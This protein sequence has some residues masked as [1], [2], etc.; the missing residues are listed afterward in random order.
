MCPLAARIQRIVIAALA[1][2]AFASALSQA[3]AQSS[4]AAG[5]APGRDWVVDPTVPGENLPPVGRSLFDFVVV[6]SQGARKAYDVPFPITALMKK[7][8]AELQPQNTR[9]PPLKAVLIPLGRSL[10][11]T[12]P[13]PDFFAY[14]RLVFTADAE[15]RTLTGSAGML[16]KDRI[17][18]GYQEKADLIEVI[19]YNEAAGRF[20]FQVVKDYRAGSTP[21]VFYANRAICTSCHQ[22]AAPI[23]SRQLWDETNAN[24][25]IAALLQKEKRSF[26]GVEPDRGVDIPYGL[27][28]ATDRANLFSA[29]QLLW[30]EACEAR[31]QE[32]KALRCRAALYTAALQYRLSGRQQFDRAA[33]GFREHVLPVFAR[34]AREYWPAG[35]KIANADM[36]NRDPLVVSAG[37]SIARPATR[38]ASGAPYV[39]N[40]D[41]HAVFDPLLPRAPAETWQVA[42][43][44]TLNRLVA[45]LSEFIAE[46]DV[47][48]LSDHLASRARGGKAVRTTYEAGCELTRTQRSARDYRLEFRCSAD[49][50]GADRSAS[51]QGRFY[52]EAAKLPYGAIDR[53][54][55]ADQGSAGGDLRDLDVAGGRVTRDSATLQIARGPAQARRADGNAIETVQIVW[56]RSGGRE[57]PNDKLSGRATVTVVNDFAPVH[58]AVEHIL[59]ETA[60]GKLDVFSNRPF[61]RASLM[62]ALF[63][64]MGM[65]RLAWCCVNDIDM[66]PAVMESHTTVA[67]AGADATTKPLALQPFYRY[68]ATC[69]QSNDRSP[70]NFLQGSASTVTANLAH[71]AQRLYVRLSMWQLAP[72][73]RPKTPMPPHYALYGFHV[74][75]QTWRESRELAALTAYVE[76]ALQAES[77]KVPPP[78]EL[79]SR[80]YEN[81]RACLP[82]GS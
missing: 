11:R 33:E 37:L 30:R 82:E 58:A 26:Y 35:L 2:V 6:R 61:R 51:L 13:A 55:F 69:H 8:E 12:S 34:T 17:Y 24:R 64:R 70:P 74:A 50:A 46:S 29:Y 28:N 68:C 77:G 31:Q 57:N 76:R 32:D 73:E 40:V 63:D 20:E 59:H 44:A 54:A 18:L 39:E 81:L 66:P 16:L 10:Q 47:Q 56:H 36:P 4:G 7:L 1:G 72:G 21:R 53:L 60:T 23:F 45:G 22:N 65:A 19:S 71:C 38:P 79:V 49:P 48:R 75:P 42:E 67:Q 9:T 62:P 27:D 25:A 5:A 80:G 52:L 3:L 41:V 78:Q 43:P 14:P 15:P